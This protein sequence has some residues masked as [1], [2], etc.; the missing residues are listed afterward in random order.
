MFSPTSADGQQ[1]GGANLPIDDL[2]LVPRSTLA[3]LYAHIA[4]EQERFPARRLRQA[5][6]IVRGMLS[7]RRP[8]VKGGS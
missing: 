1:A 2:V 6:Q 4:A 5:L 7:T 3:R 8:H